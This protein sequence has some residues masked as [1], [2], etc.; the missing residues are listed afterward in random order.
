MRQNQSDMNRKQRNEPNESSAVSKTFISVAL[1]VLAADVYYFFVEDALT[2]IA[3]VAAIALGMT[4]FLVL[5]TV[6]KCTCNV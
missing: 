1:M 3:H 6:L 2:T 5:Q 4:T